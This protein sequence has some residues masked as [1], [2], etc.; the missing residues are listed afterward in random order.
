MSKRAEVRRLVEVELE[1]YLALC[2]DDGATPTAQGFVVH[3]QE[4][5]DFIEGK[6]PDAR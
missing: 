2:A 3:L 1:E 4:E 6:V 5:V